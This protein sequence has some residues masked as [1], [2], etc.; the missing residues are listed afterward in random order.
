M[1]KKFVKY[2]LTFALLC[3]LLN[4]IQEPVLATEATEEECL[5]ENLVD[6]GTDEKSC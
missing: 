6:R 1:I 2:F 4:L 3:S 5:H